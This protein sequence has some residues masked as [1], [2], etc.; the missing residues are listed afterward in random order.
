MAKFLD[1]QSI[2]SELLKLIKEAKDKIILISPYLKV[3]TQIQERL[4]T[5]SVSGIMSEIVIVYGKTEL[6]DSE[7]EWM[8]SIKDLKVIEKSNLHAKCYLNEDKAIIC[9]MN[10]HDYSMQNNIEM[11]LMITKE[12]DKETYN[13]LIEEINNIKVNGTRKDPSTLKNFNQNNFNGSEKVAESDDNVDDNKGKELTLE[14]KMKFLI[15]KEWRLFKSKEYK[16]KAYTILTDSEIISLVIENNIDKNI[17]YKILPAKKVN[18]FGNEIFSAL[19]QAERYTICK[20]LSV[21]YQSDDSKYDRI[22][23]K[24]L[25]SSQEFW[26][27]TT[28]E[29]PI[30]N[31]HVA[32]S[33]DN[34]WFNEYFY[35]D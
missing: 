23:L 15:L 21:I 6:K 11:G 19:S 17:L 22:K 1:T 30:I 5:K 24:I 16:T 8:K 13:E 32:A 33:L 18:Q 9:S 34:H 35:L 3:N 31:R 7:R 28:K 10:L 20:V 25:N 14:Q 26:F 29:L 4:K 2:S 27:E 12:Q